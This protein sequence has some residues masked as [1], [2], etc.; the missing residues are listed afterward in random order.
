[1]IRK[2]NPNKQVLVVP[3]WLKDIYQG[4]KEGNNMLQ[5][6]Q[7]PDGDWVT[8]PEVLTDPVWGGLTI[9]VTSPEGET[10]PAKDFLVLKNYV[11]WEEE[12]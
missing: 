3:V 2:V 5:A 4:Y 10:K 6:Q 1:M 12:L 7:D 8:A 9:E 11:Y